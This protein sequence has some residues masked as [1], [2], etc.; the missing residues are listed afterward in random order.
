[1]MGFGL[2]DKQSE[3]GGAES[4]PQN[5]LRACVLKSMVPTSLEAHKRTN[6]WGHKEA[7]T[8]VCS[9]REEKES[10]G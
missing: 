8:R 4:L 6:M 10:G 7:E 9:P 5:A 1:M 3:G 2:S